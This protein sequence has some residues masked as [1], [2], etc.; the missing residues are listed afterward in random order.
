VNPNGKPEG[1]TRRVKASD[2]M[3]VRRRRTNKK[4]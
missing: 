2:R 4:R 1:R 3:I